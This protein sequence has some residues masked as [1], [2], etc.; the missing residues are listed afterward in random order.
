MRR[1]FAKSI[2]SEGVNGNLG[3]KFHWGKLFYVDHVTKHARAGHV[4]HTVKDN[5]L[6][7]VFENGKVVIP[8]L[9]HERARVWDLINSMPAE[10]RDDGVP[11]VRASTSNNPIR[12]QED[13]MRF[14][15]S[16]RASRPEAG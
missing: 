4:S 12:T 11:R 7:L 9:I 2:D 8:P 5:Q 16:Q 6:E 1:G 3:H 13:L 14:L 15:E 10:V